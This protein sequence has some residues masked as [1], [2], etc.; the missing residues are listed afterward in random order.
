LK[1]QQ[2]G[3]LYM[4]VLASLFVMSLLCSTLF[5][6]MISSIQQYG[7]LME[8]DKT[9]QAMILYMEEGKANWANGTSSESDEPASV[10]MTNFQRI[11]EANQDGVQVLSVIAYRHGEEIHRFTTYLLEPSQ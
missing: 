1:A 11:V 8:E 4:D 2:E 5:V 7:K 9:L 10:G 6:L 3:F